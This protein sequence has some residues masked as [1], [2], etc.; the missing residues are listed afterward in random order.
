MQWMQS[1][2]P[3]TKEKVERK[4]EKVSYYISFSFS[5][6]FSLGLIKEGLDRTGESLW[7]IVVGITKRRKHVP[8]NTCSGSSWRIPTTQNLQIQIHTRWWR[9][10]KE[11]VL[12]DL[13]S[14]S[15][16]FFLD[17]FFSPHR[18]WHSE[19][20]IVK[21]Q[22]KVLNFHFKS[23]FLFYFHSLTHNIVFFVVLGL[24]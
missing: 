8:G 24:S 5:T 18:L 16:S 20:R 17:E 21:M 23:G 14:P 12:L 6:P 10:R 19:F 2:I 22:E 7:V 9:G 4:L 1:Q 13:S 11:K 15:L 3:T